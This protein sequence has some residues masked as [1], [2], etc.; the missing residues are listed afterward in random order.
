M[1]LGTLKYSICKNPAD[2]EKSL[3]LFL[4]KPGVRVFFLRHHGCL[5]VWVGNLACHTQ[6]GCP[7]RFDILTFHI[8]SSSKHYWTTCMIPC[9]WTVHQA[10][11]EVPPWLEEIAESAVGTGYGPAGGRFGSRDTRRQVKK[12]TSFYNHYF[13]NGLSMAWLSQSHNLCFVS[14]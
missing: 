14:H 2:L 1:A 3:L 5:F 7:T 6:L 12:D 8:T 9:V 11:Q 13:T 10:S 4:L